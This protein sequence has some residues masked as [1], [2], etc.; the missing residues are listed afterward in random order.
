MAKNSIVVWLV[1]LVVAI[2]LVNLLLDVF[3]TIKT[4]KGR[5]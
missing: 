2:V 3:R 1:S 4:K 5:E